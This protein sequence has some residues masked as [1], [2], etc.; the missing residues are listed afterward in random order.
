MYDEEAKE[1]S[2]VNARP[3]MRAEAKVVRQEGN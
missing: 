1:G 2:L 3:C